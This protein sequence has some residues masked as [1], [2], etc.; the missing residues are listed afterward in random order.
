MCKSLKVN[1]I[2]QICK[3]L[4]LEKELDNFKF[5]GLFKY[6]SAITSN[7]DTGGNYNE[8]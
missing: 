8:N 2:I 4:M 7:L 6:R 3:V 5:V 1:Y